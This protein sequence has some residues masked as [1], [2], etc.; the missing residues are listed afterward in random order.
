MAT[1][2]IDTALKLSKIGRGDSAYPYMMDD[3]YIQ[4][5]D[6]DLS[7]FADWEP[8]G[9]KSANPTSFF[10]GTYTNT[11]NPATN[12]YYTI[13]GLTI[14]NGLGYRCFGLFGAIGINTAKPP[15]G[16]VLDGITIVA[17][18]SVIGGSPNNY[19]GAVCGY[20]YSGTIKNCSNAIAVTTN[21]ERVGGICG[22]SYGVAGT[23][24][25]AVI[26][27]CKNTGNI[28]GGQYTGGICGYNR[29]TDE[30][31]QG[32]ITACYN[33]GAVTCDSAV[34]AGQVGGICGH[35]E[36]KFSPISACYN[37]G[38]VSADAKGY[39]GGVCGWA[40]T[41]TVI[42]GCY[43]VG[44]TGPTYGIGYADDIGGGTNTG[45]LPFSATNWPSTAV[46]PEWGTG[47]GGDKAYWKTL[48]TPP[49]N[50]PVL[51]WE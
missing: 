50:Y 19:A 44:G 36:D 30:D 28:S 13:S 42:T 17:P 1:W 39:A 49:S 24:L 23:D 20:N 6:I 41:S 37:T 16:A 33:T 12:K 9:G 47:S 35:N 7:G 18:G 25:T 32:Q 40:Q 21:V 38:A 27:A 26:A 43:W 29:G 31:M 51:W 5:A 34:V 11:I 45:A 4:T 2:N 22:Y 48:G 8:I 3:D 15:Q 14:S 10:T 46:D